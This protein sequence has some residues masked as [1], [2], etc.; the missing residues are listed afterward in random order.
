GRFPELARFR[1]HQ[2]IPAGFLVDR[3]G[4]R[5]CRVGRARI[6]ERHGNFFLNAGGASA[7][8]VVM[9]TGLAKE[10]VHRTYGVLLEE[11]VQYVGF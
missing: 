3:A 8:E 9:L 1:E 7:E 2:A 11:E 6:S 5:G 4:L 10:R